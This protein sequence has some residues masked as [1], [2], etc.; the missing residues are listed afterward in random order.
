MIPLDHPGDFLSPY[1]GRRREGNSPKPGVQSQ[2]IAK[3]INQLTCRIFNRATYE[4]ELDLNK[5]TIY[6]D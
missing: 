4:K 1:T 5:M 3:L 2:E 6:M